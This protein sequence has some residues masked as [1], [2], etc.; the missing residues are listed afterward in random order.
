MLLVARKR[1]KAIF[2]PFIFVYHVQKRFRS[3]IEMRGKAL[4]ENS[5]TFRQFDDVFSAT[6]AVGLMLP[7]SSGKI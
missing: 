6:E 3:S 5:V 7:G 1:L 2:H 4:R